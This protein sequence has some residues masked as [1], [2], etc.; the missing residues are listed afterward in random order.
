MELSYLEYVTSRWNICDVDPL[1]V[2]VG[3]V[4]IIATRT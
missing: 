4:D 2:N 1:A 3:M